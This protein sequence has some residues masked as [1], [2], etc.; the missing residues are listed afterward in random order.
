MSATDPRD[1]ANVTAGAGTGASPSVLRRLLHTLLVLAVPLALVALTVRVVATGALMRLE[2]AAADIAPP[3][4]MSEAERDEAADL[5]R[6]YV[7]GLLPRTHVEELLR[8]GEPLYTPDEIAHLDD[9][10]AVFRGLWGVGLAA[11]LFLLAFSRVPA[12]RRA[13]DGARAVTRGASLTIA[14]VAVLGA[15]I[16]LAFDV[17]FE[18]FHDLFFP[19]GTWTFPAESGLISLFPERFWRDAAIACAVLLVAEGLWLRA[20]FGR[21]AA[22]LGSDVDPGL[23][24]GPGSDLADEP[25]RSAGGRAAAHGDG[26]R[27]APGTR[28]V[29]GDD[30]R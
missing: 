13:V 11:W 17:V 1:F 21:F 8:A 12:L 22:G 4:G 25:G 23:G 5:T 9:V 19:P 3:P 18:R 2:Y 29:R 16:L 30:G 24:P 15:G 26:D 6:L 10:R 7:V 20:I 27:D 14:A 28:D